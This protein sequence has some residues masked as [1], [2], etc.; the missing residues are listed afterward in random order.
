LNLCDT[1]TGRRFKNAFLIERGDFVKLP[2]IG[3]F[4]SGVGGITVLKP[5]LTLLPHLNYHYL[6]DVA[7]L[8]YGDRDP[9]EVKEFALEIVRYLIQRGASAVV[10]ACNISSS[11][12]LVEAQKEHPAIPIFGV[13]Q[14]GIRGALKASQNRRIGI[15]LTRATYNSKGYPRGF[16]RVGVPVTLF[17]IPC[18]EWVPLVESGDWSS[19]KSLEIIE[20]YASRMRMLGVDTV[21]LGCTHYPYLEPQ[22]RRFTGEDVKIVDPAE[23][24]A[25]EVF[26]ALSQQ[27]HFKKVSR[28]GEIRFTLTAPSPSFR[29]L[30]SLFLGYEIPEPEVINLPES[31]ERVPS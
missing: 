23:E 10:M 22:I 13:V 28:V 1:L 12:A 5:L 16:E 30:A 17:D 20:K 11:V 25:L 3:I 4:D 7:H 6:G 18:P 2:E 8:P 31:L 9:K 14:A 24:T 21:I 19:Q 29:H 26:R 15:F 27:D